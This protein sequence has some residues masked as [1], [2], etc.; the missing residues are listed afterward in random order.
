MVA[1]VPTTEVVAISMKGR[2]VLVLS[3]DSMARSPS[4]ALGFMTF[5]D[6]FLGVC[7]ALSP[8]VNRFG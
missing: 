4:L 2:V 8:D 6:C 7:Q 3:C 5:A 1:A